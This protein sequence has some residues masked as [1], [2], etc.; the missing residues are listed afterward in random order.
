[1]L[2]SLFWQLVCYIDTVA[3]LKVMLLNVF[4]AVRCLI[5]QSFLDYDWD[6][7]GNSAH[8]VPRSFVL[9]PLIRGLND[10]VHHKDFG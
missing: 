9:G 10:V 1:M 3:I 8:I 5:M 6:K 2:N 4:V 7:Y